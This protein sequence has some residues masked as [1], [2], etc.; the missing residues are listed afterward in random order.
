[1]RAILHRSHPGVKSMVGVGVFGADGMR[2]VT[3]WI[4]ALD[5]RPLRDAAQQYLLALDAQDADKDAIRQS[6]ID[7]ARLN[8]VP[9]CDFNKAL[10]YVADTTQ[11]VLVLGAGDRRLLQCTR[12][13]RTNEELVL[14]AARHHFGTSGHRLE[15]ID[16]LPVEKPIV[17]E[18]PIVTGTP[19][20]KHRAVPRIEE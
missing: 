14:M 18:A 1:M 12:A 17:A 2:D 20:T 5:V 7:H 11:E 4:A 15:V 13:G 10:R 19:R 8:G 16:D 9:D 3:G 6:V